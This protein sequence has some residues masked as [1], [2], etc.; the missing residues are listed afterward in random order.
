MRSILFRTMQLLSCILLLAIGLSFADPALAASLGADHIAGFFLGGGATGGV[1]FAVASIAG[2]PFPI[3]Q[4]L[5]ATSIAYKNT[6]L[7]ADEVLPRIP[8]SKKE[9]KWYKWTKEE[10]YTLPDTRVGRKS[11]PNQVEFTASEETG[12]A[13]DYG[14]DDPIPQDDIDNAPMGLDPRG[15]AAESLTDLI[16]LDREVRTAR[17]VFDANLYAAA[18]KTTLSG[19]SQFSHADSD[20]IATITAALDKP[21]LRP[22]VGVIGRAAY[23]ILSQHEKIVQATKNIGGSTA[24][25]AMRRAIAELFEL[26]DLLVGEGFVNTAKRGQNPVFE[27]VWGKHLLLLHRNRLAR[28][29]MSGTARPTFGFTAQVGN[30][31]A[32][33]MVDAN[34]GL[35]GGQTV[36]V[37]E[38]VEE[39]IS[40]ADLGYFFQNVVA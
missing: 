1:T 33:S 12:I 4:E 27:R 32:G 14:L 40:A 10:G 19:T 25:I 34:I 13:K 28:P 21:L 20:P 38:T 22:N 2:R 30:R 31:L 36:R 18:N 11:R 23:T 7:I 5:V 17:K 3:D 16:L 24:G 9:Y 29:T 26:E 15:H 39:Q 6:S 35:R 37:G 8:V